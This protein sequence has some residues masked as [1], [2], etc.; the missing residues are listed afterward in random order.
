MLQSAWMQPHT[1]TPMPRKAEVDLSEILVQPEVLA[2]QVPAE[3]PRLRNILVTLHIR[4]MEKWAAALYIFTSTLGALLIG[5]FWL[6]YTDSGVNAHSWL[7]EWIQGHPPKVVA[8]S[9]AIVPLPE[10]APLT[11]EQ[12]A[13]QSSLSSLSTLPLLSLNPSGA[14]GSPQVVAPVLPPP[15]VSP[16]PPVIPPNTSGDGGA[17]GVVG[18]LTQLD[19]L[20]PQPKPAASAVARR[21]TITK[22]TNKH[23]SHSKAVS[24]TRRFLR[25]LRI[26]QRPET[27]LASGDSHRANRH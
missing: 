14:F 19:K 5:N 4:T 1:L 21:S 17:S 16:P 15:P 13:A 25:F 6:D 27:R 10:T 12:P 2:R 9:T 23:V 26:G 24:I 18:S 22:K 20:P 7:E 8:Y 3:S 11:Q